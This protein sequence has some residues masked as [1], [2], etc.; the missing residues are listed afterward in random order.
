MC[1]AVAMAIVP[2]LRWRE[3]VVARKVTGLLQDVSW[4]DL[5]DVARPDSGFELRRLAS[6]GNPYSAVLNPATSEDDVRR[7]KELFA[8][9]CVKCHGDGAAG[10]AGPRLVGRALK[11]G[12]SDWALYRT[13]TR[14]VA[15]TAMQGG[16]VPR[17]DVWK[18]IAYL[19]DLG[20][21]GRA[22]GPGATARA[23]AA[24]GAYP[25]VTGARLLESSAGLGEWMT[26]GGSYNGQRYSQDAQIRADNVAKLKAHWIH[27]LPPSETP[28][29]STP[30]VVGDYMYVTSPPNI[31]TAIDTRTG[32]EVWQYARALPSDLRLCCLA[33]NRGVA[34]LGRRV[35]LAT[36]DAH[37]VALDARD[38]HVLWDTRVAEYAEGYSMTSAPLAID[39]MVVV[40]I[41]GGD[42]PTRGFLSAYDGHSGALRWRFHAVPEPGEPGNDTWAGDS[43]RTG[44]GATWGIGSYD[45][46]LK[47]LYW[48][49]GNP[50]PDYDAAA[51]AGD[52][53]YSNCVVAIDVTSG[54]LVWYFQFS[55]GDDHDWDAI[56]TPALID[57]SDNATT[58]NVLAVANRNGFFYVLD[59][60]TGQFI[61][62][63]PFVRQTW[64]V[65]LS[66]AGRPIRAEQSRPTPTGTYLYPSVSGATNWWPSAYSPIERLYYVNVVERG[67]LFFN[68]EPASKPHTG[69]MYTSGMTRNVEGEPFADY[70]RAIDPL[71]AAVRWERRNVTPTT[72]PRGGLLATAG[73]LL[74]GSDG[75]VLY[76]LNAATGAE[77]WRFD[78]GGQI[79]AP[80]M[81]YRE[82][83]KQVIAVVAAHDV[84]T[85]VL[86]SP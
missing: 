21:Q 46:E 78:T 45:P 79:S 67:G 22:A 35:Y 32:Q 9:T 48:G 33:T 58:K 41:A 18:V 57:V 24:P 77:L 23:A 86:P 10:G 30:I 31:V 27:Q 81:T 20:R 63:A 11:H 2:R 59:R 84:D 49:V 47:L 36:L 6:S 71:S 54:K 34:V 74:F 53:L 38:G 69:R 29:E 73:G 44:G 75:S 8:I 62:G 13:I 37:L 43:W 28:N 39:D 85:F 17:G 1:T 5:L 14:G 72:A 42:Y 4:A 70:V 82:D 66:A 3:V 12:D 76:A 56:Q 64:A 15:R 55:P 51:R 68:A 83:G 7:G 50:A 80:P 26:P 19:R 16:F 40:G 61:R 52:N 60:R 25:E 65:G